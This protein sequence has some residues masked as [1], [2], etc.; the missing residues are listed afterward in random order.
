MRER[1]KGAESSDADYNKV[2]GCTVE[3]VGRTVN[4]QQKLKMLR[5][6]KKRKL[7]FEVSGWI[8]CNDYIMRKILTGK[9]IIMKRNQPNSVKN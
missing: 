7:C 5:R 4:R 1:V 9:V 3:T 2:L 8:L 6:G